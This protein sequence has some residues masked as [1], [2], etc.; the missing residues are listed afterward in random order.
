[1]RAPRSATA[2]ECPWATAMRTSTARARAAAQLSSRVPA[3]GRLA[4]AAVLDRVELEV[5]VLVQLVA[6]D[7]VLRVGRDAEGDRRPGGQGGAQALG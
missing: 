5:G 2:P 6:V 3:G 1:M 7:A 4:G